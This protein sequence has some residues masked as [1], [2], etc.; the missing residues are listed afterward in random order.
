MKS[1]VEENVE[2][3]LHGYGI[4]KDLLFETK[5]KPL[6]VILMDLPTWTQKISVN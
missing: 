1:Q 3:Y 4:W 5:Q 2:A 6:W